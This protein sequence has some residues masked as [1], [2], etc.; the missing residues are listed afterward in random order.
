MTISYFEQEQ[1]PKE[2]G[3]QTPAYAIGFELYENGISRALSLDYN[4]FVVTGKLTSL[5]IKDE[6]KTVCP[7]RPKR[8]SSGRFERQ[9]P[10]TTASSPKRA[11][12]CRPRVRPRRRG[13][14]RDRP[15]R[16]GR[17]LTS[18]LRRRRSGGTR[19]VGLAFQQVAAGGENARAPVGSGIERT[20]A[21]CGF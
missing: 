5:E 14:R 20:G 9:A 10:R 8:A 19:A 21:A 18:A 17:R 1:E 6:P 3:E 7:L 15:D 11:R 2:T 4:D 16:L 12:S 13:R